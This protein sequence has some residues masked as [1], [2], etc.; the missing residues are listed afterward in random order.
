M[1]DNFPRCLNLLLADEGGWV[2]HDPATNGPPTN[3]GITWPMYRQWQVDMGIHP[4]ITLLGYN[5]LKTLSD[6]QVAKFYWQVFWWPLGC[7]SLPAGLD[8]AL[9]DA[10]VM[11][12][13]GDAVKWLQDALRVP[14][15]GKPG[16]VT[17]KAAQEADN[18]TIATLCAARKAYLSTLK[19]FPANPGWLPRVERVAQAACSMLDRPVPEIETEP[20]GAGA[21]SLP[22]GA[23]PNPGEPA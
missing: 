23:N 12:G 11:S 6:Q 18:G 1:K 5:D 14:V 10:A 15:D 13:A 8:Y 9:F 22:T 16:P 4:C 2:E 20:V 21:L 3:K 17:L 19:T 7:E